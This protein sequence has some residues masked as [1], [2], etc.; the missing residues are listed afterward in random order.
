MIQP[1]YENGF[2]IAGLDCVCD[3]EYRCENHDRD[4]EYAYWSGLA[5]RATGGSLDTATEYAD[6]V[7]AGASHYKYGGIPA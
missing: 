5:R 1:T 6:R 2:A 7:Y 4:A 3:E